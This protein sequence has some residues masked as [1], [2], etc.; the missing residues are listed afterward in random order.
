MAKLSSKKRKKSLFYGEK[1]LVGLNPVSFSFCVPHTITFSD[2]FQKKV[3]Q[4]KVWIKYN[5]TNNKNKSLANF[6]IFIFKSV[7]K[8]QIQ[9]LKGI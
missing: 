3:S 1:S 6:Q 4:R 7:K 9:K 8:K 2:F 5:T